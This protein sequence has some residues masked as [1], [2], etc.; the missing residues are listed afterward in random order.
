MVRQSPGMARQH[1]C[2]T[3]RQCVPTG[4]EPAVSRPAPPRSSHWQKV[5]ILTLLGLTLAGLLSYFLV[6]RQTKALGQRRRN[7]VHGRPPFQN[8][9]GQIGG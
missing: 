7:R 1:H 3:E 8:P 9:R 4:P 6:A 2:K 5:A